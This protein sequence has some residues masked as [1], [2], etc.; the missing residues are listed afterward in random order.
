MCAL[1]TPGGAVCGHCLRKPPRFARTVAAYAYG[2]PVDKLIQAYKFGASLQ[3]ARSLAERLVPH[4]AVRPDCIVAMPLHPLRLRERGFNQ[5]LLLAREL[6]AR[7][8]LPVLEQ[9]CHRTRNT[10]PQSGLAWRERGRNMRQA[11]ACTGAVAGKHV[12]VVDDVM[13]TGASLNELAGALKQAG[14]AEVS[15]WVVARTLP[16][17]AQP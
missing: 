15:T 9:A 17:A 7:L 6:G 4:I 10:A 14:A 5:S 13:T 1:P 3:L 2:F 11:F 12:A 8:A 16:H